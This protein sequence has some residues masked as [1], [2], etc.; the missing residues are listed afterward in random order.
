MKFLDWIVRLEWA[1]AAAAA[2]VFYGAT[3][4][5]WWLF[6]LLILAPDLSMLGY[7]GGPRVGAIAYN[8]L[9]I[10]IVPVLVL[11][12]GHLAG[13]AVGNA[14]A[15]I[16]IAHI[17][18]DRALGYGLKLSTGFQDTHLGRIGRKSETFSP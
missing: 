7:L 5:S 11:L 3:G 1:V 9:H 12:A 4:V 16:W 14:V 15:L 18:I 8:A 17:A 13:S 2:I 10:L 6:A